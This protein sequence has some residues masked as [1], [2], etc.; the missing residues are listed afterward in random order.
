MRKSILFCT[1]GLKE[2]NRTFHL[3]ECTT[4]A[5]G[6]F[7]RWLRFDKAVTSAYHILRGF[8]LFKTPLRT[9][10]PRIQAVLPL[11]RLHSPLKLKVKLKNKAPSS[12]SSTED[13]S[14]TINKNS[15]IGVEELYKCTHTQTQIFTFRYTLYLCHLL[16]V[17]CFFRLSNMQ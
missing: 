9:N 7:T 1:Q 13:L 14:G 3:S 10:A 8:F 11:G 5:P 16:T 2:K 6:R 4:P 15:N 12:E 17:Q